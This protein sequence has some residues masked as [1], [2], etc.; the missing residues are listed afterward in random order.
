VKLAD[1]R[2]GVAGFA[3]FSVDTLSDGAKTCAETP[4]LTG[5]AFTPVDETPDAVATFLNT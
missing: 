3:A 5:S 1:S 2:T 4:E